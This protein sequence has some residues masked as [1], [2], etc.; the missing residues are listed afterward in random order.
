MDICSLLRCI[1]PP[2]TS[3]LYISLLLIHILIIIELVTHSDELGAARWRSTPCSE[4]VWHRIG[5]RWRR[6][7]RRRQLW[8]SDGQQQ[9]TATDGEQPTDAAVEQRHPVDDVVES[10]R[11]GHG[12][13]VVGRHFD[14]LRRQRRAGQRQRQSEQSRCRAR[15]QQ[16]QLGKVRGAALK[17][18]IKEQAVALFKSSNFQLE[19]ITFKKLNHS[20]LRNVGKF[21][22]EFRR[23]EPVFHITR[24]MI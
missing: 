23:E 7:R 24:R 2:H 21:G 16:S 15:R 5:S 22:N 12:H 3:S 1:Y 14:H 11:A 19:E 13:G 17:T 9:P 4:Q 20:R 8:R 10:L 6:R 18:E